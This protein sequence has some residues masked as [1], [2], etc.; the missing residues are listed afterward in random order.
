MNIFNILDFAGHYDYS[1]L[2]ANTA[3]IFNLQRIAKDI[4]PA[5]IEELSIGLILIIF[6]WTTITASLKKLKCRL[7]I[8]S[9]LPTVLAICAFLFIN[10]IFTPY[11][12]VDSGGENNFPLR[13]G[14]LFFVFL[15]FI[16][17]FFADLLHPKTGS[18]VLLLSI[19]GMFIVSQFSSIENMTIAVST[20]LLV[21]I[22]ARWNKLTS[23]KFS[24]ALLILG[25]II[26]FLPSKKKG[27]NEFSDVQIQDDRNIAYAGANR[28][29]QLYDN[30]SN[31]NIP[32]INVD[33]D[34]NL[35]WNKEIK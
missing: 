4:F 17:L 31:H 3:I 33:R 9:N 32:Y 15:Y 12:A 22:L 27:E 14:L 28:H 11:S 23:A 5:L 8:N 29:F 10:Y 6:L 2:A 21:S 16:A 25:I 34:Q 18:A 13:L 7:I 26:L 19:C 24:F 35:K 30:K 1:V 20:T